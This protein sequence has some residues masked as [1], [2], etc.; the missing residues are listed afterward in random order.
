[1]ADFDHFLRH[2]GLPQ[3]ALHP[4][5]CDSAAPVARSRA[6]SFDGC[7]D[8]RPRVAMSRAAWRLI[9]PYVRRTLVI[10]LPQGSFGVAAPLALKIGQCET[11]GLVQGR[12]ALP[13]LAPQ[14]PAVGIVA[15]SRHDGAAAAYAARGLGHRA[16]IFVPTI[17]S[18]AKVARLE[19]YGR[20]SIRS[21]R[22]CRARAA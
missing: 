3:V 8:D 14:V 16:E 5:R 1:M 18:P 4:S 19:A 7:P 2:A 22:S 11:S 21:A 6:M 17:A 12:G 9:Q 20:S 13:L 15:A 10:E